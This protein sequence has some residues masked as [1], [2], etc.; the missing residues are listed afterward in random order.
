MPTSDPYHCTLAYHWLDACHQPPLPYT[1]LTGKLYCHKGAHQK[2]GPM[3]LLG[4]L[5]QTLSSVID[6]HHCIHLQLVHPAIYLCKTLAQ[7]PSLASTDD[8][9]PIVKSNSHSSAHR[10]PGTPQASAHS[11]LALP[12]MVQLPHVSA[13]S[14][15]Q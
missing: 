12:L 8:H 4:G 14:L 5:D 2:P 1:H 15:C 13:N 3:Q 9:A 6:L 7:P 10:W 11:Q